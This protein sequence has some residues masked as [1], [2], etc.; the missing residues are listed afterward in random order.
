MEPWNQGT[1]EPVMMKLV[2]R[3]KRDHFIAMAAIQVSQ[4]IYTSDI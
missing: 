4:A 1:R 2:W 3:R